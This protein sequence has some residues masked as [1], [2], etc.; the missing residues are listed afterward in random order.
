MKYFFIHNCRHIGEFH[1]TIDGKVMP[2]FIINEH[3]LKNAINNDYMKHYLKIA[4]FK[5]GDK[6]KIDESLDFLTDKG[7]EFTVMDEVNKRGEL[8][9]EEKTNS[10]LYVVDIQTI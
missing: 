1:N 10:K 5:I 4:P 8:A 3:D 6:I 2:N 7:K 9:L